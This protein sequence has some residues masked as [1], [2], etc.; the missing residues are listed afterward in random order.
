MIT[1]R[2]RKAFREHKVPNVGAVVIK[3]EEVQVQIG[4]AVAEVPAASIGMLRR[5]LKNI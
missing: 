1:T 3:S 5:P 4:A 2:M